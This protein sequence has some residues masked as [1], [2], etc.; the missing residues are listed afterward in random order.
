MCCPALPC[1]ALPCPALPCPALPCPALRRTGLGWAG[2]SW[3]AAISPLVQV[4]SS[5]VAMHQNT[6]IRRPWL[7][8]TI[9]PDPQADRRRRLVFPLRAH[10]HL[11]RPFS[12][13]SRHRRREKNTTLLLFSF[14]FS[15]H[16]P[17]PA[18][19][20]PASCCYC[21]T[22]AGKPRPALVGNPPQCSAAQVSTAD[23]PASQRNDARRSSLRT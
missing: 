8:K 4:A 21:C 11:R 7:H 14:V 16:L 13:S 18:A 23:R 20:W 6:H 12:S 10:V 17:G 22:V 15:L 19:F 2:L 5:R 3:L 9:V 1:P